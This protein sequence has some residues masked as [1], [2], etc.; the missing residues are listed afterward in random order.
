M[1][2]KDE[3]KAGNGEDGASSA[4]TTPAKTPRRRAVAAGSARKGGS[5]KRKAS[6]VDND[7]S[8]TEFKTPSK[9]GRKA[10]KKDTTK[11]EPDI[12]E[13]SE[14]S[15]P[16]SPSVKSEPHSDSEGDNNV[17]PIV[18]QE[19]Q[20]VSS[21]FLSSLTTLLT[22]PQGGHVRRLTS[23]RRLS[24]YASPGLRIIIMSHTHFSGWVG[25]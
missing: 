11:S 3:K 16:A 13:E 5:A 17:E 19:E 20:Q 6:A 7:N 14:L 15:E 24:L 18:K 9:R 12:K 23:L 4:A 21:T 1:R 10:I 2:R 25:L 8:D 22:F